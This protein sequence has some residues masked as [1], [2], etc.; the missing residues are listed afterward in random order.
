MTRTPTPVRTGLTRT[1]AAAV[2]AFGA[3]ALTACGQ[4]ESSSTPGTSESPEPSHTATVPDEGMPTDGESR[5][6]EQTIEVTIKDGTVDPSGERVE[7]SA[8]EEI[9]LVVTSDVAGE[10]HVHSTPEQSLPFEVGTTTLPLTIDQPGVAEV[11]LHDP[12]MVVVQL[13]VS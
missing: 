8:G 11:E 1:V 2:L 10:L 12:A 3:L 7:V 4:E 6:A 13:E 9:Q 5:G